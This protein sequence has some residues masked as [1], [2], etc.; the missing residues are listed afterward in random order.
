M[1]QKEGRTRLGCT[2]L[3]CLSFIALGFTM[4]TIH[5][6]ILLFLY[7]RHRHERW[8]SIIWN[9]TVICAAANLGTVV[10]CNYGSA[11]RAKSHSLTQKILSFTHFMGNCARKPGDLSP[12][13]SALLSRFDHDIWL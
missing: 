3:P 2:A 9:P 13:G 5:T 10:P 6:K 12:G 4:L 7:F 1:K 11:H 8:N